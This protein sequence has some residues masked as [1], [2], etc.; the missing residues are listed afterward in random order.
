MSMASGVFEMNHRVDPPIKS[1]DDNEKGPGDD[2]EKR[3]VDDK[4]I[5]FTTLPSLV[6]P[7]LM[8]GLG[9]S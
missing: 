7:H 2:N 4:F 3:P 1:W 5:T 9:L 6:A 8:R